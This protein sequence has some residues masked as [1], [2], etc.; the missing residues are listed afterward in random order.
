VREAGVREAGVRAAGVRAAGVRAAGVREA[1]LFVADSEVGTTKLLATMAFFVALRFMIR[2]FFWIAILISPGE[3]FI[4]N[5]SIACR[6][7]V[8]P[9]SKSIAKLGPRAEIKAQAMNSAG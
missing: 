9:S 3:Y 6:R 1:G 4:A 8:L 7:S 5:L 2:D